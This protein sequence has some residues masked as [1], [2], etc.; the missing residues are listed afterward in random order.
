M[1]KIITHNIFSG[2]YGLDNF[3][4]NILQTIKSQ[5]FYVLSMDIVL[6]QLSTL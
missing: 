1:T 6:D 4:R 3:L 5:I 2:L